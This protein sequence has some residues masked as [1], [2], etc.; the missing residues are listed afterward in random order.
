MED[1]T[2]LALATHYSVAS[3]K[4]MAVPVKGGHVTR[5]YLAAFLGFGLAGVKEV[6]PTDTRVGEAQ[7]RRLRL[8]QR[9]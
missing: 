7:T 5:A 4:V 2:L 3:R 6:R 9:D 8:A 1:F